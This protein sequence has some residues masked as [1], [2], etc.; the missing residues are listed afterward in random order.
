MSTAVNHVGFELFRR[1]ASR[2]VLKRLL[3]ADDVQVHLTAP[4][5]ALLQP[6]RTPRVL[7][8]V[9]FAIKMWPADQDSLTKAGQAASSSQQY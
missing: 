1:V 6:G 9:H 2:F 5:P 8:S 4:S 3:E 7:A